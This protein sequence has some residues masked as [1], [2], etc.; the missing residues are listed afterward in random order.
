[1]LHLG[2]FKGF[3]MMPVYGVI[4]ASCVTM[5]Q[6]VSELN[7][8]KIKFIERVNAF[9]SFLYSKPLCKTWPGNS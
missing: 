6:H 3:I 1:M 9:E 7:K 5:E 2:M 4:D 8:S